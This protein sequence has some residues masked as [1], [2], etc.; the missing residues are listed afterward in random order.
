MLATRLAFLVRVDARENRT[1][2]RSTCEVRLQVI[3]HRIV[4]PGLAVYRAQ[5]LHFFAIFPELYLACRS[6][7]HPDV[8]LRGVADG[9][10]VLTVHFPDLVG[11][12][13]ALA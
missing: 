4:L 10:D 5:E 8:T 1:A 9:L 7:T 13:P 11:F 2:L 3:N 6:C 12:E